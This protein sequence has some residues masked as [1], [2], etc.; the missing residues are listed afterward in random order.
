[1]ATAHDTVMTA[2]NTRSSI[3]GL[4]DSTESNT[5]SSNSTLWRNG[6]NVNSWPWLQERVCPNSLAVLNG[7]GEHLAQNRRL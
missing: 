4:Q 3:P 7:G 5:C 2:K 1:M 6:P